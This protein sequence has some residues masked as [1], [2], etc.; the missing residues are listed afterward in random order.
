VD[1]DDV[2]L[3]TLQL[4]AVVYPTH[5]EAMPVQMDRVIVGAEVLQNE[6]VTL[7]R[8]Q[9]WFVGLRV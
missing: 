5:F 9:D 1:E 4:R 7:P 6:P 2:L 8:F 3:Q